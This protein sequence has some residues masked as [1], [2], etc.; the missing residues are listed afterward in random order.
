[1]HDRLWARLI[2]E[3]ARKQ[4]FSLRSLELVDWTPA[5]GP[6][7][8]LGN[9]DTA[10]QLSRLISSEAPPEALAAYT[11]RTLE[12]L[13]DKLS[14]AIGTSV[15]RKSGDRYTLEDMW[16]GVYKKLSGANWNPD[17]KNSAEKVHQTYDLRNIYGSHYT[18]WAESLSETE[19]KDFAKAVVA[20]WTA[21]RCGTCGVFVGRRLGEKDIS[22][23]C[24]HDIND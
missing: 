14:V 2:E 15:T 13:S 6:R 18:T 9:F 3:R 19:V 23:Q 1:V 12:E 21:A 11:S 7:V 10:A 4:N 8:R 24:G 17:L 20:L 16:P 5:N 22:W